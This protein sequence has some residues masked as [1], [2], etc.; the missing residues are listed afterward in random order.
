MAHRRSRGGFVRSGPRRQTQ[1]LASVDVETET[2]LNPASVLLNQSFD[3]TQ[4][5]ALG[6][7]TITRT[8][9]SLWVAS[10]QIAADESAL[11][12]LGMSVVTQQ[13]NAAGAASVPAPFR[14]EGSESF[15]MYGIALASM[16]VAGAVAGFQQNAF[17]ARFD[18]DS[19]AQRKVQPNEAIVIVLENAAAAHRL[20][21][22][23]K[24]RI[25][26]KMG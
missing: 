1:W 7:F 16:D 4:T 10:D 11:C 18:F 12:G 8:I 15:F 21:F 24:F 5:Q 9:G 17:S 25:L 2:A 19:R 3:G 6:P 26:V 14:D 13:A 20:V 23:L 22:Y